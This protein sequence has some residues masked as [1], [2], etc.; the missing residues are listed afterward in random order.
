MN[1]NDFKAA[2]RR[3]DGAYDLDRIAR[4]LEGKRLALFLD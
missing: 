1:D 3:G 2:I 4:R